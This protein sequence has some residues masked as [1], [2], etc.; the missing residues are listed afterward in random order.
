M[1]IL[2]KHRD[3]EIPQLSAARPDLPP[4][5]D[6]LFRR[7][8]AKKPEQRVQHMSEVVAELE[9]IAATLP[10]DPEQGQPR[11]RWNCRPN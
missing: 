4:Q 3:G 1:A 8:L 10:E 7:M 9:A 5:L 11:R 6:D 2:L